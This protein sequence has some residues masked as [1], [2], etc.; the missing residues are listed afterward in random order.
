MEPT[1]IKKLASEANGET[2]K[3][4]TKDILG[5]DEKV[6]MLS[7]AYASLYLW[8]RSGG[9]AINLARGH[10]LISRVCC[11]IESPTLAQHHSKL[12]QTYTDLA[13][14]KKDFDFV[15]AFESEARVAALLQNNKKAIEL[16]AKAKKLASEIKD[17]QDRE[18]VEGDLN[19]GPWFG[20]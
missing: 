10:W 12:C 16:K 15:Y 18:I 13:E 7:C 1:E 17:A 4:L 8:A 3:Y 14:D 6:Q 2:W 5:E 11:V 19:S 9:T 20:L